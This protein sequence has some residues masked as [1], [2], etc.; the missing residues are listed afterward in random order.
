MP[1]NDILPV[2]ALYGG[3]EGAAI[4][5]NHLSA[6]EPMWFTLADVLAA[7]ML[8]GRAP[9]IVRAIRFSAKAPQ[10]GLNPIE[11]EGAEVHPAKDDFYKLLIDR[12][13]RIKSAESAAE[14]GD[15]PALN[16][17]Q[18][19][20]KILANATS[21]GIFVELNVHSLDSSSRARCFDH[22]G[23]GRMISVRKRED[24]GRYFHPL[25][26]TL[27]T[28]AARLMLALTER[29]AL[30][31]GLDWAF[32][33]TDSLAIANRAGLATP[34]FLR[35][36]EVARAWFEPL[37]PYEA[38][39][40]ILQ[41]EKVNFPVGR[42]QVMS[43]LRPVNCLAVSAKRYALFDH[44]AGGSLVIR[45]ASAHGLGHLLSPYPDPERRDRIGRIGVEL[46]QEDLWRAIISAAEAGRHDEVDLESL[47]NFDQ[48]AASR[49]AATNQTT[50]KWFDAYNAGA[51]VADRVRPFNFLLSFQAKSRV[52]MNAVDPG[53]LATDAWRKRTPHPAS[54]YSSDLTHAQPPV[55][56]RRTREPV[57]WS[58]LKTY[59]RSL[60]RHHM[61]PEL[62]FRGGGEY[63]ARGVLRRRRVHVWAVI[64]I[65][66]E[67]DNLEERE[68]LGDDP[69]DAVE[70]AMARADRAK[71]IADIDETA[72]IFQVSDRTL[73]ERA[74]VSHHTLNALRL[75]RP[76]LLHSL[77]SLV[78]AIEELRHEGEIDS[79]ADDQWLQAAAQLVSELGSVAALAAE[80]GIS[81]Q[82]LGR[83]L[84]R[85]K[86]VTPRLAA[87]LRDRLSAQPV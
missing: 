55:F 75:G 68:F 8:G 65:G 12:R 27:I 9:K 17:A 54:R 25:L 81:R 44:E 48:P 58:W 19:S 57:P 21:Y 62:K 4:G 41:L 2:R 61:H 74:H 43:E 53:A 40:P 15:K 37:N 76:V 59:G 77:L 79:A 52:E 35:R 34:E 3:S 82:Y 47:R 22:R 38:K 31:H 69:D 26:A 49:Y 83:V 73:I 23:S 67:A 66:K 29:Q 28:G 84:R 50:L 20:L 63:D 64:P 51:P 46:W 80:I 30:D 13:R 86:P 56:D 32:C 87:H 60:T 14:D 11:L 39:G 36:V 71:L 7:K 72:R 42:D 33:D 18:Q 45:K 1:D 78:R 6:N 10:S 16:A 85:Q 5:V 70:W 24:A